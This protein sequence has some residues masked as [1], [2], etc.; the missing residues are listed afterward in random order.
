VLGFATLDGARAFGMQSVT[1]SLT[2]GKDAE[3]I[4]CGPAS[5]WSR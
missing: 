4:C 1:G 2:P 3:L 5:T